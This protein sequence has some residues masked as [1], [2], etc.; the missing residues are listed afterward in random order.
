MP[1]PHKVVKPYPDRSAIFR[2][3]SF[4]RQK[5]RISAYPEGQGIFSS[6]G[7]LPGTRE[8]REFLS[9][10]GLN[11]LVM[12][13]AYI[14]FLSRAHADKRWWYRASVTTVEMQ[15][16]K[17][18]E[19]SVE[20]RLDELLQ[21]RGYSW[22]G[23]L[24]L[25]EPTYRIRQ[26]LSDIEGVV[27]EDGTVSMWGYF[28]SRLKAFDASRW[29]ALPVKV[30]VRIDPQELEDGIR[31]HTVLDEKNLTRDVLVGFVRRFWSAREKEF[32]QEPVWEGREDTMALLVAQAIEDYTN[33]DS[34][35]REVNTL[36]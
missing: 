12:P 32:E 25:Q 11:E 17:L 36:V 28:L 5:Q 35:A 3:F 15:A 26:D 18:F 27:G 33:L 4:W 16:L 13:R 30:G 24:R 34:Q 19:E 21:E 6:S 20:D 14:A 8:S 2:R 1:H 10:S 9:E 7:M 23:V 22:E 29:E 31:L